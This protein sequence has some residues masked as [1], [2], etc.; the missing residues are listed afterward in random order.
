MIFASV[1]IIVHE[2]LFY[3]A[4]EI[5]AAQ[6]LFREKACLVDRFLLC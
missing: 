3:S 5:T 6:M 4:T 2:S 1:N